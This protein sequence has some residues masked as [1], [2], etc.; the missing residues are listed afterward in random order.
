MNNRIS[1][2]SAAY[3]KT[4]SVKKLSSG[5]EYGV[6]AFDMLASLID[7]EWKHS[8]HW[9]GEHSAKLD[10]MAESL[11]SELCHAKNRLAELKLAK[12]ILSR[13]DREDEGNER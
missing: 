9:P 7:S 13:I 3:E 8:W 12:S 4:F 5:V 6:T 2:Y 10:A 1:P 11:N